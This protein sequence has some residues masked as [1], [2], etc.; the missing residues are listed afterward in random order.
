MKCNTAYGPWEP[1]FATDTD[2]QIWRLDYEFFGHWHLQQRNPNEAGW[3]SVAQGS[4]DSLQHW[5]RKQRR[6]GN[7]SLHRELGIRVSGS[8]DTRLKRLRPDIII[9]GTGDD[10]S[11]VGGIGTSW[12]AHVSTTVYAE[13]DGEGGFS[14]W[15]RRCE[16][17]N[18]SEYFGSGSG[19]T[20]AQDIID[21][22][23]EDGADSIN[24]GCEE[25]Q[26]RMDPFL[27]SVAL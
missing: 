3:Q 25:L 16:Q 9:V 7:T 17:F 23:I 10:Y 19:Y 6:A 20:D 21:G 8:Y 4:L 11:A 13:P 24:F 18:E 12:V 26:K 5:A 1:V 22:A 27:L 14:L 2:G 15:S